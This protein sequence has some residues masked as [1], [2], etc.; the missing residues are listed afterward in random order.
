VDIR[1][2][3]AKETTLATLAP[4]L[5]N[6]ENAPPERKLRAES[7]SC[8]EPGRLIFRPNLLCTSSAKSWALESSVGRSSA[9][10]WAWLSTTEPSATPP[11][12][13]ARVRIPRT[14]KVPKP[15]PRPF[16]AR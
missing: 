15:R 14:I 16:L 11:S 12:T 1:T 8:C 10:C 9:S 6:V 13:S 4:T 5:T 3:A 2:T 7:R